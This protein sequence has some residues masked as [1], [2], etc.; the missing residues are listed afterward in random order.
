[1]SFWPGTVKPLIS[2]PEQQRAEDRAQERADDA[3]PE[4]VGDEDRE[5]PEG[6]AH[7]HPHQRA[8][9]RGL[10]CRR[11]RGFFGLSDRRRRRRRRRSPAAPGC[12]PARSP[13]GPRA[14]AAAAG[15]AAG[16]AAAAAWAA[17][18][19]RVAPRCRGCATMSSNSSRETC[20]G[21]CGAVTDARR[22]ALALGLDVDRRRPRSRPRRPARSR[23]RRGSGG[24]GVAYTG[25]RSFQCTSTGPAMK[26]DEYVPESVP[27]SSANAKS[28]QRLAA[29]QEQR[30]HR[31]RRAEARSPAS[32]R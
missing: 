4:A 28:L 31:Q 9:Q 7:H 8:H 5:V 29:E 6:E 15:G 30:D 14:G 18:R 17:W 22:A 20:V 2:E 13:L 1:M 21:S 27:M 3:R 23:A 32:A 25:S 19:R 12:R 16:R 11:L 10:P 24:S 26:T